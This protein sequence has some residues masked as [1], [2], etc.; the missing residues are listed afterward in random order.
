MQRFLRA[1]FLLTA[2][3]LAGMQLTAQTD[4]SLHLKSGLIP[5]KE[6]PSLPA[7]SLSEFQ[8]SLFN[9]NYYL[10]LQFETLPTVEAKEK[11]IQAGIRLLDYIPNFSF[12]AQVNKN[13]SVNQLKAFGVRMAMPL[14]AQ[15]K[16]APAL[17]KAD[18]PAHAVFDA[19]HIAVS[20][21]PY[22]SVTRAQLA[23]LLLSQ[24]F[25]SSN[26]V[27]LHNGLE[28][29]IPIK[30]L[31]KLA[32]LAPVMYI[33][34]IE[35]TPVPDGIRGRSSHRANTLSPRP[36]V[37]FDGS[38]VVLADA[39]DGS[40]IHIDFHGRLTDLTDGDPGGDHGDM[41]LGIAG[42]AANLD[43]TV[44]GMA[45][46]A[47]LILYDINTYPQ[48]VDAIS[49]FHNLGTVVTTTSY[50]Q[51]CGGEYEATATDLDADLYTENEILHVFSAGNSAT[52][53]CSNIYGSFTDPDGRYYGNI[54][55]GRK[56]A[57]NSIATANLLYTDVRDNSSSRGPCE[58]GRLKPDISAHG[59]DQRSTGEFNTYQ[60]GG[61]TSAASPGIGGVSAMLYQAYKE[62]HGGNNPDGSFIKALMLN[63]ADDMGRP[64]PDFDYGWGRV[65]AKSA[66]EAMKNNQYVDATIQQD[67]THT[68][69]IIVPAG[70]KRLK[71][72]V[73]WLD[74]AGSP[75]ASKAL[76]NDLD[77]TVTMPNNLGVLNPWVLKTAAHIDSVQ[78]IATRGIDRINN[79]EQVTLDNPP[80]GTYIVDVNGFAIPSNSQKYHLIYSFIMDE[81]VVTYPYGGEHF[82][83]GRNEVIR[84]DAFGVSTPFSLA[85]SADSGQNWINIATV[86]AARRY[87]DWNVPA[88]IGPNTMVRVTR[89]A[90]SDASEVFNIMRQPN[91]NNFQFQP[92]GLSSADLSWNAVTGADVYDIFTLGAKYMDSIGTTTGTTFSLSN[93]VA[94][95]DV[96]LAVRAR[97]NDGTVGQRSTARLFSFAPASVCEG[98]NEQITAFPHFQSFEDGLGNWCNFGND[99]FDWTRSWGSTPSANTGPQG[100]DEGTYYLY[101]EATSPNNP[102][103]VAILGSPCLKPSGLS[104]FKMYFSYNMSG[105]NMG[106]MEVQVTTNNGQNWS[107]SIWSKSGDQG[108]NW[109]RDSIDLSSYMGGTFALRII[110]TTGNGFA[111]DMAIDNILF[112]GTDTCTSFQVNPTVLDEACSGQNNGSISLATS[113]G[114]GPL[115]FAW[116]N[117]TTSSS[118]SNLA[119]GFYQVSISDTTGCTQNKG[120]IV[121]SAT[122][123]TAQFVVDDVPCHGDTS[124][125]AIYATFLGGNGGFTANWSNGA[126]GASINNL[127][128]G[129]YS[130]T[131]TDARGCSFQDNVRVSDPAPIQPGA[132]VNNI[133]CFGFGNGSIF[134]TPQGG[135]PQYFYT[136]ST[137]SFTSFQGNL[138][139]GTYSVTISDSKNCSTMASFTIVEPPQLEV[140]FAITNESVAGAMDGSVT[141]TATGGTPPYTGYQ[142]SVGPNQQTISGLSAGMYLITVSDNN[143]CRVRDTAI[144]GVEPGMALGALLPLNDVQLYPNPAQNEIVIS[145]SSE[146]R[147]EAVQLQLVDMMGRTLHTEVVRINSGANSFKLDVSELSAGTYLVDLRAE[148]GHLTRMFVKVE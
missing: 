136:W 141:A 14:A 90:Q 17:A 131:V 132:E 101:T 118:L 144:V 68:H 4:Y 31:N 75:A 122:P 129:N 111:S 97:R 126:T 5:A 18:F 40:V 63:T 9:G 88:N 113:G 115:S 59:T 26:S 135:S 7:Q 3:L 11:M 100:A 85:Y 99:H 119:P 73:L 13:V 81:L 15:H 145:L 29:I 125:G 38:G 20:I 53:S 42:G 112:A 139:A 123:I 117:G 50:S 70:V 108:N 79:M 39:D 37:G 121:R 44:P 91:S 103:R 102:N 12:L 71:V 60:D 94:G 55:G 80:V 19:D 76:V 127:A 67:S 104:D 62:S 23:Q 147:M 128:P 64:G 65:N 54:T 116:A 142:W 25:E 84:W 28:A 45:T 107:T 93:L 72:M 87:F 92:T 86:A 146:E 138:S 82:I 61:G 143:I 33:Q 105:N 6:L 56:A 8:A 89:G 133:S 1:L 58:D 47:D 46:G 69:E 30:E 137:G 98:C 57:K 22:A 106:S 124:G 41:T 109:I 35:G 96:W 130:V 21:L 110:G 120:Y 27:F 52:S 49:N 24:G 48:I 140:S 74:P 32:S 77:M 16:L 10:L 2:S 83:P 78:A 43:P 66:Y 34:P 134:L 36:G 148:S 51:G 114:N 95:K